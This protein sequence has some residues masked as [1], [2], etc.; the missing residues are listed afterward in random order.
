MSWPLTDLANFRGNLRLG[1]NSAGASRL[2]QS[3]LTGYFEDPPDAQTLATIDL[4]SVILRLTH[5][6][7]PLK[8]K[9][10]RFGVVRRGRRFLAELSAGGRQGN[11]GAEPQWRLF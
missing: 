8:S 3:L 10:A 6:A 2:W 1:K 5:S 11:S 4:I 7:A 9:G